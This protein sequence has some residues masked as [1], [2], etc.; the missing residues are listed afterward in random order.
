MPRRYFARH[1][2]KA[3]RRRVA[4]PETYNHGFCKY[5]F[6]WPDHGINSRRRLALVGK[7]PLPVELLQKGIN[8]KIDD[9]SVRSR[10]RKV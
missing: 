6:D 3:G 10:L 2:L 5:C 9:I 4:A 1:W 7:D 8:S